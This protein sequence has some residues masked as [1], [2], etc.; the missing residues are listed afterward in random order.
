MGDL[1]GRGAVVATTKEDLVRHLDESVLEE[2]GAK[3]TEDGIDVVRLGYSDLIGTERGRDVLVNRFART[4]GDGIA[5]CRSVYGTTPMGDVVDMEGGM[6][7]GLPD[8]VAYPDLA[9]LQAVPWAPG[10]ASCI[11]DVFNPDGSP[12][13]ESPRHGLHRGAK[14]GWAPQRPA[15]PRPAD[16]AGKP[17]HLHQTRRQTG[18]RLGNDRENTAGHPRH[19]GRRAGQALGLHPLVRRHDRRLRAHRRM[20]A[21]E[22]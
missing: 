17:G 9:T 10:V 12:S 11:A 1:A 20:S 18:R 8:V 14:H 22:R 4:V 15:R 7:A 3:L 5:F 19:R 13:A 2:A 6:S 16:S 21:D